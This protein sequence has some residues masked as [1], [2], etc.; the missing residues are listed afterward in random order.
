MKKNLIILTLLVAL[1]TSCSTVEEQTDVVEFVCETENISYAKDIVPILTTN[2]YECH[3]EEE[4]ASKAD[5]NLLEGYEAIKKKIDE[6]LVLGNINHEK[7]F[8]AMPYRRAQ[9]DSCSRLIIKS[10]IEAGAP[11]N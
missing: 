8:I 1:M 7:G 9:I 3:N 2:C 11:N 4:Y 5:G 10:W 6:G